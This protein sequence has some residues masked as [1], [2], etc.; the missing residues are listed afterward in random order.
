MENIVQ[1]GGLIV[2]ATVYISIGV[3]VTLGSIHL[4]QKMFA[5]RAE[6]IFYALILIPI[7]AFYWACIAYFESPQALPLE[8]S[9]IVLFIGLALAGTKNVWVLTLAYVLH[10]VWDGVHE[11]SAHLS[12]ASIDSLKLTEIPLTYGFFCA[13]FDIGIAVYFL[14]RK[15]V[16]DAAASGASNNA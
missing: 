15:K 13:T 16:W 7:A 3:V 4:S 1:T 8:S 6:Q 14:S 11:F 12:M 10:G 5:P 2:I 9:A